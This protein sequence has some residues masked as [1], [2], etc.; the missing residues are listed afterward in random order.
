RIDFPGEDR[1]HLSRFNTTVGSV[2]SRTRRQCNNKVTSDGVIDRNP[3]GKYTATGLL[4]RPFFCVNELRWASD[5][6]TIECN[7]SLS[8]TDDGW[9]MT[10]VERTW[11]SLDAIACRNGFLQLQHYYHRQVGV[12]STNRSWLDLDDA[13]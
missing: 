1:V 4:I 2:S 10:S 6:E 13:E 11:E 9:D 3:T 7:V 12:F 5:E 8:L